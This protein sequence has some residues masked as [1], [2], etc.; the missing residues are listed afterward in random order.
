MG[1]LTLVW[2][3]D[4][5]NWGVL[6]TWVSLFDESKISSFHRVFSASTMHRYIT[7]ARQ[8]SDNEIHALYRMH[9]DSFVS[10]VFL[11]GL[12]LT[13]EKCRNEQQT[14]LRV[15][16]YTLVVDCRCGEPQSSG[17]I[18]K[19]RDMCSTELKGAA[20]TWSSY[21]NRFVSLNWHLQSFSSV[22][23]RTASGTWRR[24]MTT[25]TT[26][27]VVVR[28]RF[29]TS[30]CNIYVLS[31]RY[32]ELFNGSKKKLMGLLNLFDWYCTNC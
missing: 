10:V 8:G 3:F 9:H 12:F 24:F 25:Y 16:D 28:D 15:K 26:I 29:P 14:T 18:D 11:S 17:Q 13:Q 5:P 19:V 20:G 21:W 27:P 2:S 1:Y 7:S 31:P 22:L 4:Y 32:K 23:T 30:N 6:S